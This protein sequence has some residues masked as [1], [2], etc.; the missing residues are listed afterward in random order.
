LQVP[1]STPQMNLVIPSVSEESSIEQKSSLDR[2]AA[3]SSALAGFL[4]SLE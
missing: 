4:A 3:S 2:R 1:N